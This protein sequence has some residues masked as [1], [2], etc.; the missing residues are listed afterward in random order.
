[1]PNHLPTD[2]ERLGRE[3]DWNLLRTFMMVVQE[4]SITNAALRLCLTQPA[5]SLAL[6]RLE[7]RL[8]RRLIERGGGK[9][10][11]TD[12][13]RSIYRE[14][15]D[16]YGSIT[17][18]GSLVSGTREEMS[19]HV[20]LLMI[21]RVQT[22]YLDQAM[23]EF[24][25]MHPQVTFRVEVMA[26]ADVH[27]GLQQKMGSL[28]ICLM[29]SPVPGLEAEVL[30]RQTYRLYCGAPHPLFARPGLRIADLR[31]ENFVSFVSDQIDGMLSPLALFRARE[32]FAGRVI[33]SSSNLD[34][35]RRMIVCGLGIGPLPEHIAAADVAAGLLRELPP[36][37]GV[38]PVDIFVAWNPAARATQAEIAFRRHLLSKIEHIPIPERLP[39]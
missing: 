21:S 34:E 31:Q 17:R 37:D 29:R 3:L 23:Q 24:H 19:G 2:P 25:Q 12:A 18:F 8:G 26:T 27:V 16:I 11:L 9:F 30:V 10:E 15:R 7:Q 5:V 35:V 1:M 36:A 20:R 38:A 14:V 22:R 13:G 32:G 33:A 6:K 28:G 39:G 4:G